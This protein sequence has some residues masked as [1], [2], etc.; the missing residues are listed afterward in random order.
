MFGV[1]LK[2]VQSYMDKKF[3]GFKAKYNFDS[4]VYE[5]QIRSLQSRLDSQQARLKKLTEYLGVE[6]SETC[7]KGFSKIKKTTKKKK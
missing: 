5:S 7:T 4:H 1:S 2:E 3:N 6:Y